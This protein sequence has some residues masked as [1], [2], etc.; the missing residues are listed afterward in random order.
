MDFDND[1]AMQKKWKAFVRKI[2]TKTDDYSTV[3]KTIKTFLTKPFI[4]A[5]E[6]NAFTDNW[7]A[8]NYKWQ[9]EE[10]Q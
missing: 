9:Q 7:I 4:A 1:S 6:G 10:E 8:L 3:L 5:V 2:D